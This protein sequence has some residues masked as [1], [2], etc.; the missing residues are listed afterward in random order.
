MTYLSWE[1]KRYILDCVGE[2]GLVLFEWMMSKAGIPEYEFT[3]DKSAAATGWSK[4]K[5][6]E[7]RLKLEKANL[8]SKES[9]VGSNNK[10]MNIYTIGQK[11]QDRLDKK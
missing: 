11:I 8:F 4:R 10:K 7:T 5:C 2:A 6:Q 1:E 9:Y 3:D